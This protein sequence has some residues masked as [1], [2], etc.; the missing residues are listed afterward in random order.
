MKKSKARDRL[1]M[2]NDSSRDFIWRK[3]TIFW[4]RIGSAG[5]AGGG[6]RRAQLY[7]QREWVAAMQTRRGCGGKLQRLKGKVGISFLFSF[8]FSLSAG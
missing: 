8:Y 5:S 3:K 6:L 7:V 4:G 1:E 2:A